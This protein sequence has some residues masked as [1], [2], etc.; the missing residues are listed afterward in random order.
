M[1]NSTFR[2][3]T[4]D[5]A[6]QKLRPR[7]GGPSASRRRKF[8]SVAILVMRCLVTVSAQTP[9]TLS[10]TNLSWQECFRLTASHH[11][12]LLAAQ[13][14]VRA[15]RSGLAAIQSELLPQLSLYT[16][17]THT[18]RDGQS[19]SDNAALDAT[20]SAE[21]VLYS[22]GR[23]SAAIE[24]ARAALALAWADQR[25]INVELTYHL[26]IA[27]VNLLAAQSRVGVVQQIEQRRRENSELVR[28]RYEGGREH[29]GSLAMIEAGLVQAQ[30]ELRQAERARKT[31]C[32][33]LLYTMGWTNGPDELV[34]VEDFKAAP[35]P[36]GVDVVA[37]AEQ[38]PDIDKALAQLRSAEAALASARSGNRPD[39][40]L[41]G[42]AGRSG[43]TGSFD[44]D[45]W[46][47]GIRLSFPFWSGG[48]TRHE[49]DQAGAQRR[50]AEEQLAEQRL[51]VIEN[52]YDVLQSYENAVEDEQV[53]MR[54]FEAADLRAEIAR[55]QYGAGLLSFEN[56]DVIENERI[57]YQRQLLDAQR[58]TLLAEAA[59]NY[60]TGYDAFSTISEVSP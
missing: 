37:L 57:A 31:A 59:W 10:R 30:T 25:A 47:V 39:L 29:K 20:V 53:Q 56:W 54:Y 26:R 34:V 43:D 17:A 35:P 14:R 50:V 32:R 6:M 13:E 44:T 3:H 45:Q 49:V 46:S 33:L 24:S 40:R 38:T 27:F 55:Q 8:I 5:C 36:K 11:P 19:A 18:E 9:Q 41:V 1:L 7:K 48:R 51:Q 58:L 15:A 28:L 21:Q 60:A 22:G 52:L 2:V 4:V 16:G 23:N 12:S 42:S